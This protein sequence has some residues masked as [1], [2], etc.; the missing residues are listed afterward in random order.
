M[1]YIKRKDFYRT[2]WEVWKAEKQDNGEFFLLDECIAS[3][4]HE[5]H[6]DKFVEMMN[7]ASNNNLESDNSTQAVKP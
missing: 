2:R 1:K 5:H 7:T 4:L 6:A 3:F